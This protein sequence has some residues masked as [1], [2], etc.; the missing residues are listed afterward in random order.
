[1]GALVSGL[2]KT[3]ELPRFEGPI[4]RGPGPVGRFLFGDKAGEFGMGPMW[5]LWFLIVFTTAGPLVA[6]AVSKVVRG[7]MRDRVDAA[8]GWLLRHGLIPL[9]LAIVCV[10][11][12][13]IAGTP[14]GRPP[15]GMTAIGASFPDVMF[16]Y[17]P[18]WPYFMTYFM[19]GW[20]LFR[21]RRDLDVLGGF[22]LPT[23]IVGLCAH[24]YAKTLGGGGM[25]F[26]PGPEMALGTQVLGYGVFALAATCTSFGLLGLFQR[27]LNRPSTI[28]RYLAETAFW[29]YLLHQELLTQG[30]LPRLQ[31]LGLPWWL[32][33]LTALGL[34]MAISFMTYEI[35]I[36][37]TPL[38]HLFGSGSDARRG[39]KP[40]A[41]ATH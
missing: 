14:V 4:G 11:V 8:I 6:W 21:Y 2:E 32:Q 24:S 5:F 13:W 40:G 1:M 31:P 7:T 39:S 3:V 9:V 34:V 37:S 30:I 17:H 19:T 15:D 23:L 28:P 35:L 38:R 29:I 16:R 36:R 26:Q 12:L 25:P 33:L 27:Y 41:A 22:W 20:V 10:P 18:D